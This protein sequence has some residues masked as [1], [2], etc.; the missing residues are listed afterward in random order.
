M[1]NLFE[2]KY[3]ETYYFAS[4]IRNILSDR[5]SYLGIIHDFFVDD[6][7]LYMLKPFPKYSAF[8]SF[9]EFVL[10]YTITDETE[11]VD[12]QERKVILKN[13][14][15]IKPAME[16]L[17]PT[18]LPIELALDYHQIEFTTF[19]EWLRENEISFSKCTENDISEY[20]QYLREGGEI[21]SLIEIVT[22][23]VFYI[24]FQ[25]RDLLLL[26]NDMVSDKVSQYSIS[27]L[28]DEFS[29]FFKRDGVLNRVHIPTWVQRAI[30]FRDRGICVLCRK[31]ISGLV[32]NLCGF[33]VS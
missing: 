32:L 10:H 21:E 18:T 2:V 14:S 8:H 31:D 20:L 3:Y 13:F 9:I 25:N 16:D 12:L 26:F 28:N 19:N 11:E 23:E 5:F 15:R 27:D 6:S 7:C 22:K 1:K 30:Y 4:M 29:T 17:R 33:S 24:L